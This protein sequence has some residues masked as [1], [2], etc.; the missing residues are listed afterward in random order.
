MEPEPMDKVQRDIQEHNRLINRLRR[1][2]EQYQN[3]LQRYMRLAGF[4]DAVIQTGK[5]LGIS[6]NIIISDPKD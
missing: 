6:P 1:G 4:A 3:G 2:L 5:T